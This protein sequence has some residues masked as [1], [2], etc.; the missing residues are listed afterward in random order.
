MML[1][2]GP[3]CFIQNDTEMLFMPCTLERCKGICLK[4][5]TDLT[6]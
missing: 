5:I 3:G 6:H 4:P 1:Q 2:S